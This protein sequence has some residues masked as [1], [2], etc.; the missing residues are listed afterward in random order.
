MINYD[1]K[2]YKK[3]CVQKLSKI[4]NTEI[5]DKTTV[6]NSKQCRDIRNVGAKSSANALLIV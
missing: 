5:K 3:S 4:K 6:L 1:Y 2:N